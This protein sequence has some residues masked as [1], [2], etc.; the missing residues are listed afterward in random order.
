MAWSPIQ[1]KKQDI[2]NSSG[3]KVEVNG[4]GGLEQNLKKGREEI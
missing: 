3:V 2:N 1:P 4:E